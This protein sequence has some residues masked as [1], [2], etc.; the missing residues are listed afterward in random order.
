MMSSIHI[1][2]IKDIYLNVTVN[3]TS[4]KEKIE[5]VDEEVEI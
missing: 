1:A 2:D 3:V 4:L 5:Y